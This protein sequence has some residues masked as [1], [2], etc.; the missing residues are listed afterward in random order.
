MNFV[1]RHNSGICVLP[2]CPK[3]KK[4][5]T[6][7]FEIRTSTRI[8]FKVNVTVTEMFEDLDPLLSLNTSSTTY[9]CKLPLVEGMVLVV[10]NILGCVI[11]GTGNLITCATIYTTDSL[12]TISSYYICGLAATDLLVTLLAQPMVVA[13][14][15]RKTTHGQYLI[16]VEYAARLIGNTSCSASILTLSFMSLDRCAVILKPLRYRRFMTTSKLKIIFTVVWSLSL[17]APALD[18]FISDKTVYTTYVVVGVI[19]CYAIILTC[20]CLIFLQMKKQS[21]TRL[22][23]QNGNQG[24]INA[25]LEVEKKLAKTVGLVIG[26]FTVFWAPFLYELVTSPEVNYGPAYIW[27]VTASL[28]NSSC[29]PLI[30]FYKGGTFRQPLKNMLN[31]RLGWIKW[32]HRI[33]ASVQKLPNEISSAPNLFIMSSTT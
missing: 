9:R 24:A 22:R 21:K 19:F 25:A 4:P 11:G 33:S 30:Y 3:Q 15:L 14:L 5:N 17:V 23:L 29:N 18:A 20:Y 7:P 26:V 31:H 32:R 1:T 8:I 10:L 6:G 27:S 12:H 16:Q 13:I 2:S 28:T